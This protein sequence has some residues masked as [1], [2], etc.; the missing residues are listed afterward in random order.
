MIT[1]IIIG[2]DIT[3]L[4]EKKNEKIIASRLRRQTI[5]TK[6]QLFFNFESVN[7]NCHQILKTDAIMLIL[8]DFFSN[9][10]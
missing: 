10:P 9:R 2:D 5:L 4:N 8:K 3:R 1:F 7:K 6:N